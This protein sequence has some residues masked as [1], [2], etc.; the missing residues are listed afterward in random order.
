MWY[1]HI[2]QNYLS[3]IVLRSDSTVPWKQ[4]LPSIALPGF[5]MKSLGGISRCWQELPPALP[6]HSCSAVEWQKRAERSPGVKDNSQSSAVFFF[7]N[8]S[9]GEP[10]VPDE[11]AQHL[12]LPQV[13]ARRGLRIC[14]VCQ[15]GGYPSS[16]AFGAPELFLP[17]FW[18]SPEFHKWSSRGATKA[19]APFKPAMI[20]GVPGGLADRSGFHCGEVWDR[21]RRGRPVKGRAG[22]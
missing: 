14:V 22:S 18:S 1:L 19:T 4:G 21:L 12:L 13:K 3:H 20:S 10:A 6:T 7:Q 11:R 8:S 2:C 15:C 17:Q 9:E 16:S 5:F